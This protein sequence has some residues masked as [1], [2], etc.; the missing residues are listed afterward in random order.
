MESHVGSVLMLCSVLVDFLIRHGKITEET[1]PNFL[2]ISTRLRGRFGYEEW[3]N[4]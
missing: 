1:E 3:H 4:L 2:Q